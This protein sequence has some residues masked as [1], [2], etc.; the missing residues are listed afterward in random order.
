MNIYE[1]PGMQ[2]GICEPEIARAIRREFGTD[3][4]IE[5]DAGLG[6]VKV[7]RSADPQVVSFAIEGA[8]YTVTRV[9]HPDP[10][11]SPDTP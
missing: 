5:V 4:A 9:I 7:S 2:P 1:V 11:L 6:R 8:G 3:V 10:P